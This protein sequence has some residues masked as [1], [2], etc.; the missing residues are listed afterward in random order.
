MNCV[1]LP[2]QPLP[3]CR[4]RQITPEWIKTADTITTNT[5][6]SFT[7]RE[8]WTGFDELDIDLYLPLIS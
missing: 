4:L 6:S 2:Q 1:C 7:R 5:D 3:A 8:Q